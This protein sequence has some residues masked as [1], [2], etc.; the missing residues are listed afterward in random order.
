MNGTE[1]NGKNGTEDNS[2]SGS[3]TNPDAPDPV[4]TLV[5]EQNAK[6]EPIPHTAIVECLNRAAKTSFSPASDNTRRFIK[7]RW[8]EGY[9]LADFERVIAT[10]CAQWMRDPKM[11]V[12]LRPQ[13]LFGPKFEAYLNEAT[14]APQAIPCIECG[15]LGG[16]H[17]YDCS[18]SRTAQ[19]EPQEKAAAEFDDGLPGEQAERAELADFPELEEERNE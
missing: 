19:E 6:K 1:R 7:A 12:Y 11:V 15:L 18:H 9:R 8:N 17:K 13:T 3:E 10:K 14:A 16:K 4:L 5:D 2:M